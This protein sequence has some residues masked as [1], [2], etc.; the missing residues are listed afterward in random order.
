MVDDTARTQESPHPQPLS[1]S[2]R[3]ELFWSECRNEGEGTYP[4]QRV[5]FPAAQRMPWA[6]SFR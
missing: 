1:R 2:G 3:G 5:Y 6:T 4:A